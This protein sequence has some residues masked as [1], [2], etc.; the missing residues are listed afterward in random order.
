VIEI[1]NIKKI[2]K[3]KV[4]LNGISSTF[5]RGKVNLVIGSSGEGKSVLLKCMVGLIIPEDGEVLFDNRSF[6]NGDNL[7]K[8]SIRK[9][10]GMLFQGNALFDSKNVEENV[11]FPLDMLTKLSYTDKLDRVN[12]CLNRV[13]LRNVNK[14]MPDELSGGMKKR[15]GIARA[16]ANNSKYLFCDEPNSGLDPKTSLLIDDLIRTITYESGLVTIIVTHDI[17]SVVSLGDY[18]LFIEKGIKAWE[19]TSDEVLH[20]N[21]GPLVD[22]LFVNKLIKL[23]KHGL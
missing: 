23:A 4:V 19:G 8:T 3:D 18:I 21:D 10:I 1:R 7:T 15:V 9:E 17:N 11:M 6:I 16:I 13:G 20:V 5:A 14:K 22:F 12:F 2:F